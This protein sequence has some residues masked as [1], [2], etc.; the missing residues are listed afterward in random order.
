[1]AA[2]T[3]ER[4]ART[5]PMDSLDV[6]W[7]RQAELVAE[8]L[9]TAPPGSRL[10]ISARRQTGKTTFWERIRRAHPRHYLMDFRTRTMPADVDF[11][12]IDEPVRLPREFWEDPRQA[13]VRVV[14]IGTVREPE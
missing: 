12:F 2:H 7:D 1:M 10:H 13:N 4:R 14:S 11:V 8:F 9:R 6:F 3:F 5:L